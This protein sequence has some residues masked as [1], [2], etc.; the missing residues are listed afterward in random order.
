MKPNWGSCNTYMRMY[1]ARFHKKSRRDI[2]IHRN[3]KCE[4]LIHLYDIE[5]VE[6]I[7][8]LYSTFKY[9]MNREGFMDKV[10]EAKYTR[11]MVFG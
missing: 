2:A 5:P 8:P 3:T 4:I 10:D 9:R 7:E 1:N 11:V 6:L